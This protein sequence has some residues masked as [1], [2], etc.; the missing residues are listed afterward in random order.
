MRSSWRVPVLASLCPP[1]ALAIACGA[2]R[3]PARSS[4]SVEP[5]GPASAEP[6]PRKSVERAQRAH[7][8][9]SAEPADPARSSEGAERAEPA[10]SEPPDAGIR[11]AGGK[12][13]KMPD[14]E[15]L[16]EGAP[17]CTPEDVRKRSCTV[18]SRVGVCFSGRCWTRDFCSRFCE[19]QADAFDAGCSFDPEQ[20]RG[21]AECL[22]EAEQLDRE[23]AQKRERRLQ[24]CLN[25][26]CKIL[27]PGQPSR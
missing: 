5:T 16:K 9:K 11:R 1:I 22:S 13:R 17:P 27:S 10:P 4:G 14:L 18:G 2:E 20:C 8:S 23:C 6:T 3:E 12:K 24:G 19:A 21:H 25:V 7:S 15:K 26:L